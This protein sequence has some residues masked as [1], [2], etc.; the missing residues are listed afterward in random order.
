MHGVVKPPAKRVPEI[1][2]DIDEVLE[3]LGFTANELE[4]LR[5]N[6]AIFI[7]ERREVG[8]MGAEP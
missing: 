4:R 6:H 8:P 2:E 1:G 5:A 3:Q 7:V